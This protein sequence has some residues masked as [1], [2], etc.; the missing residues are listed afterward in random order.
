MRVADIGN[1]NRPQLVAI[2]SEHGMPPSV[3]DDSAAVAI[4]IGQWEQFHIEFTVAAY[5][6]QRG[7]I[8]AVIINAMM[9]DPRE[10]V[11]VSALQVL[12]RAD[13]I[14]DGTLSNAEAC[15]RES[16]GRMEPIQLQAVFRGLVTGLQAFEGRGRKVRES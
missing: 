11:R 7:V 13:Q 8:P 6:N 16:M 4:A 2:L 3:L 14:D 1:M 5:L 10:S 15:F 9:A 12:G